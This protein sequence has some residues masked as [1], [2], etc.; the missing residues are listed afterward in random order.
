MA[1]TL[2]QRAMAGLADGRA[3]HYMRGGA[4][5]PTVVFESGLG[6]SRS[7]WGLVAPLVAQH[8]STVVY[9]RANL[10]RSDPDAAPRTLERLTSDLGEL[11]TALGRGPYI[12]VGHSY[13]GTIALSAALQDR[14][15]VAGLVL[16]DHSDEHV[17]VCCGSPLKQLRRIA[18]AGRW[19]VGLLRRLHLVTLAVHRAAPG[20]PADVVHDLVAED[21]TVDAEGA[22]DAEERFFIEGLQSLRRRGHDLGAVPVTVI[23]GTKTTPWDR[24]LRMEFLKAH[25]LTAA[26]LRARHVLARKSGHLVVFTEPQLIADEI[27]RIAARAVPESAQPPGPR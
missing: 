17:N 18:A 20:M 13:G 25:R 23:S 2:G 7:E 15:H 3:L 11:L 9:D 6:A 1:H 12:L 5:Q 14:S 24:S 27:V 4:G 26:H 22:A 21:L 19:F 10:G 16:V 8:F